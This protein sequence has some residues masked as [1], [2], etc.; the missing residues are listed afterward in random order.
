MM[1]KL[2]YLVAGIVVVFMMAITWVAAAAPSYENPFDG[3]Y[4]PQ[5]DKLK[6]QGTAQLVFL[7]MDSRRKP[8]PGAVLIYNSLQGRDL[9]A[10]ADANGI[11]VLKAKDAEIFYAKSCIV[12]GQEYP[13]AGSTL[14]TEFTKQ[15]AFKGDV[16]WQVVS[17]YNSKTYVIFKSC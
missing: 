2:R 11:V 12:G 10:T 1:K 16:H 5:A 13:I 14:V 17:R 9:E 4:K 3:V 15:Q 6:T 7:F 8:I